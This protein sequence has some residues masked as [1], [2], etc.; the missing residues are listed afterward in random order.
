MDMKVFGR[1]W[2]FSAEPFPAYRAEIW[3]GRNKHARALLPVRDLTPNARGVLDVGT[4]RVIKAREKGTILLVPG[5][6]TTDRILALI[7][8]AGGFRGDV[9]LST[10][11]PSTAQILVQAYASAACESTAAWACLFEP[12]Q[13]LVVRS[14]GRYGDTIIVYTHTGAALIEVRMDRTEYAAL[15]AEEGTA[16]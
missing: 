11:Y 7:S 1:T 4:F 9:G 16:L 15:H 14:W 2:T 10:Q 6:D 8:V 13:R 3:H 12:G 5:A